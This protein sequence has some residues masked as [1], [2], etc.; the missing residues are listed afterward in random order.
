[1]KKS[2][3]IIPIIFPLLIFCQLTIIDKVSNALPGDTMAA[4]SKQKPFRF[5]TNVP[6]NLFQIAKS[7][8]KKNNL[9]GLLITAG[10]TAL[11]LPFDQQVTNGVKNFS[12]QIHLDG[13]TDF[14]VPVK[15][16]QTKIIKI[17]QNLN[18]ALYQLGEGGTSMLLAGGLFLY[19][20]I[21]HNKTA[22]YTASDL[23]ETFITMGIATQIIKRI[24]GRQSPFMATK[25]G[26]E[27]N[28]LPSFK[29]YQSNTSNYDAF[30]S[31]H[32]ATMMATVTTLTL[33]YPQKKWIKQVGYTIMAL[34]S[35]AMINT[36]VHWIADYP[37]ALALGYAAAKITHFKN[38][39]KSKIIN[40]SPI[41]RF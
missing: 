27:W 4:T 9:K 37:L 15:I 38:H 33:N 20:K 17:P 16:G 25:P 18:T 5:I 39:P 7:P 41:V 28:P 23:T 36:D 12:R 19:G 8:F 11:L 30:P 35:F 32:L 31:G 14:K 3:V 10:A 6:D 22:I 26:G 21:K 13:E 1:M 24:T 40:Q 34:S 2:I 29:N